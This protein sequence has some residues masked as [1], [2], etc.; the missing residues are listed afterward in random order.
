STQPLNQKS[1]QSYYAKFLSIERELKDLHFETSEPDNDYLINSAQCFK[2]ATQI[3]LRLVAFNGGISSEQIQTTHAKLL[4]ELRLVIHERQRR[5]SFPLWL[6]FIAACA[7]SEDTDR[8][9]VMDLFFTIN[10]KWPISNIAT[11]LKAITTIWQGRDLGA[12]SSSWRQDWQETIE[13]FG[14]KLSLS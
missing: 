1:A 2:L 9:I 4:D 10:S 8:K 14:W 13:K 7:C 12:T 5:R 11:V 6:L 3:Y